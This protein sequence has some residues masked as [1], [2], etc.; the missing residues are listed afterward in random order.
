MT[1]KIL[2]MKIQMCFEMRQRAK[3]DFLNNSTTSRRRRNEGPGKVQIVKDQFQ[4]VNEC[5][6]DEQ[7]KKAQFVSG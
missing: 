4:S 5:Y 1:E 3:P 6:G 7:S 2:S